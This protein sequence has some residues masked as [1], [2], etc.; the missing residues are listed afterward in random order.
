[1]PSS[2]DHI[3]FE[4]L[5]DLAEQRIVPSEQEPLLAHLQSCS[6]CSQ[7]WR[8]LDHLVGLM[9]TD[10]SVDAPQPLIARA[11]NIF[12]R[13]LGRESASPSLL[14]RLVASLN[15]DS[16][17]AE[18]AFGFRSGPAEARQLIYSAEEIDLD[19]RIAPLDDRWRLSGQVLGAECGGGEVRLQSESGTESAPLNELCEFSLSPVTP[20]SY[21]LS[22]RLEDVEVEFPELKIKA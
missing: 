3:S 11:L 21:R 10:D 22:L 15:F 4:V 6:D 20:G 14:R 9:R 2:T 18:P 17:S 5:A 8:R 16:F 19:L 7:S 1:M 12:Q 13:P